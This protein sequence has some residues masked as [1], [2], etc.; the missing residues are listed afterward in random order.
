MPAVTNPQQGDVHVSRPLTDFGQKYMQDLSTFVGLRVVPNLPVRHRFDDYWEY[1]RGDW[2][3]DEVRR[4]AVGTESIGVGYTLSQDAYKCDVWA[5]H[6]DAH[7]QQVDNADDQITLEED[8]AAL[9]AQRQMIRREH[10]VADAIFKTGVWNWSVDVPANQK[11]DVAAVGAADTIIKYIRDA[12]RTMQQESGFR[13]NR[14]LISR[15]GFDALMDNED[16]LERI[17]GGATTQQPADV[18][19]GLLAML[20]E[21]DEIMV[22]NGIVNQSIEGEDDDFQFIGG[23]HMLLYYAS[24]SVRRFQPIAA[25]QFSWSG[26][27]GATDNG[28]R[29]KRF[30]VETVEAW[31]VETQS[32]F[33]YKVISKFLGYMFLECNNLGA[34]RASL[35]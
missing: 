23:N 25:M 3:R 11:F 4:R 32:A 12:Q 14:I 6:F 16:I 13:P 9:C 27:R 28:F 18:M 17:L 20:F 7:D 33:V 15:K 34:N 22:F 30:R 19:R 29:T 26:F 21:V 10:L 8:G 2:F 31:R 1:N 24:P 35:P 5:I